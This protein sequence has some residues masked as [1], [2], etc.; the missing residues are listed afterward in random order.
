MDKNMNQTLTNSIENYEKSYRVL[1]VEEARKPEFSAKQYRILL[2]HVSDIE[3]ETFPNSK[4]LMPISV[5]QNYHEGAKL[6]AALKC[7]NKNFKEVVIIVGDTIQRYTHAAHQNKTHEELFGFA[8]TEG[9]K[10]LE[11]NSSIIK[12]SLTKPYKLVRW[13]HYSKHHKFSHYL[14][15]VED[16][17]QSGDSEYKF[18]FEK[19]TKDFLQRAGRADANLASNSVALCLQYLKEECTCMCLWAEEE[20]CDFL[21]YP[22]GINNVFRATYK[23]FIKGPYNGIMKEIPYGIKGK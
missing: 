7:M 16:Y 20:G 1:S 4:C 22:Y 3:K 8:E 10:W 23:K 17:Y 19:D 13:E 15:L 11:R 6:E 9:D 12:A 21:A 2:S 5:G 14:S 18:A